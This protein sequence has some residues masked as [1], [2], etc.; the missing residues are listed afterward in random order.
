METSY[1]SSNEFLKLYVSSLFELE[2]AT[3]YIDRLVIDFEEIIND[4]NS[5]L[6]K[7]NFFLYQKRIQKHKNSFVTK[8]LRH[9]NYKY[10]DNSEEDLFDSKIYRLACKLYELIK[11]KKF[12]ENLDLAINEIDN[13]KNIYSNLK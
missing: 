8:K 11:S 5:V 3:R 13:L 2:L 1:T 6:K 4:P 7:C 10:V 9:Q 12:T